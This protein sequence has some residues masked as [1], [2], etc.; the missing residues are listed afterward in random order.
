[1]DD[2]LE[3]LE[4]TVVGERL[5]ESVPRPLIHVAQ[6]HGLI[7]AKMESVACVASQT[8]V[9]IFTCVRD[10]RITG[11]ADI[12]I[13]VIRVPLRRLHPCVGR[14]YWDSG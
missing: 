13:S 11:H 6:C 1:M 3:T 2:A 10:L 12:V 14:K 7:K 5:D 9:W 4:P 8:H